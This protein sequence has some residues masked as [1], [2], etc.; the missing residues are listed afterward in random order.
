MAV[1]LGKPISKPGATDQLTLIGWIR[2]FDTLTDLAW[3]D[4]SWDVADCISFLSK[5]RNQ[6]QGARWQ[7]SVWEKA[8]TS[9]YDEALSKVLRSSRYRAHVIGALAHADVLFSHG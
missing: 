4:I 3:V 8:D 6:L 9:S 1:L 2:I 7:E 5:T